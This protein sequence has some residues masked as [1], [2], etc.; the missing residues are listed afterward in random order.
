M[1]NYTGSVFFL[2]GHVPSLLYREKIS[3]ITIFFCRESDRCENVVIGSFRR[4]PR[5]I[6]F[7]RL[8]VR[9]SAFITVQQLIATI[10]VKRT[11]SFSHLDSVSIKINSLRYI[12]EI[13]RNM[14]PCGI[15]NLTSTQCKRSICITVY[16]PLYLLRKFSI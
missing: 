15:A 6:M 13:K 10:F 5:G 3:L 14:C 1:C 4:T 7:F 8:F 2:P 12:E 11:G 9:L 16:L